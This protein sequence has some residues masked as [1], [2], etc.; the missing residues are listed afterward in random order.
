[1]NNSELR[2]IVG[3]ALAKHR[4]FGG[5]SEYYTGPENALALEI[6]QSIG[7]WVTVPL[8]NGAATVK[9]MM[10]AAKAALSEVMK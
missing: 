5:G 4:K 9:N 8:I 7:E 10:R 6:M 3:A 2:A 1:M